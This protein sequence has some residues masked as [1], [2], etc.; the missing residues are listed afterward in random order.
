MSVNDEIL[1]A[2][3]GPTINDGLM[4]WFGRLKDETLQDAE[5]RWLKGGDGAVGESINDLWY[6]FL[7]AALFTGSLNDM[8]LSYWTAQL[9]PEP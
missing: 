9:T 3:G 6:T 8:K 4:V 2:T 5:Q 1:R 7:R